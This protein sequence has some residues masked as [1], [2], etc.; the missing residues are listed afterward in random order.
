MAGTLLTQARSDAKKILNS[1]G[2]ESD[3]KITKGVQTVNC[4]GLAPVHHIQIDTEGQPVNSKTAHVTV[5]ESD[6]AGLTV[7]NTQGEVYLR[8]AIVEFSD[9][10]GVNKKYS[11][12]EN[13]A[14]D[15]LGVI[16]LMLAAY[17]AGNN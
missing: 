17:D 11:V 2:F 7:R 1:G 16:V 5:H 3:I 6:L 8:T 10:T 4:K 13:F 14:D 12:K 9:V 15:T